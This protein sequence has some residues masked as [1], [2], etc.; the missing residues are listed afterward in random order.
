M[1]RRSQTRRPGARRRAE[2][3][4]RLAEAVAAA[5]LQLKGYRILAK[6]YKTPLGEVD[7]IARRGRAIAF[8]EV[9]ARSDMRAALEAVTPQQRRRSARAVLAYLMRHP[10]AADCDLRFDVVVVRPF[11]LP[12]HFPNAWSVEAEGLP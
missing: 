9:K 10:E 2:R 12:R 8:V 5:W 7:L 4:G 1:A 6:R 3:R 11:A